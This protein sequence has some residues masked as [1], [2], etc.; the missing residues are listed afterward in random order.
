MVVIIPIETLDWLLEDVNPPVR[1]LTKEYLLDE[2]PSERELQEVNNYIPINTILSLMKKDGSWN[3]PKD[4]YKK[5]TGT[6]WQFIFLSEMQA[7]PADERIKKAAEHIFDYQLPDGGFSHR[8]SFKKP[9]ICLSANI[10]RSFVHF[11]YINHR[12]V[13]TGIDMITNHVIE[14]QGVFCLDPIYTLLPDCQMALMKVL[15]LYAALEEKNE[16]AQK[17]IRIIEDKIVE[18]NIFQYVPA[19]AKEYKKAING[20]KTSEIR[21]IKASMMKDLNKMEKKETKMSWTKFGFPHSYTS[22]A[23]EILYWLA[24]AD[25]T[26]RHEYEKAIDLVIAKMDKSGKWINENTFRNPMLVEIEAKKSFSKW[27]TFRA[28]YVLKKFRDLRFFE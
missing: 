6:Y 18:N 20:K 7:N 26:D 11:G 5:Y 17:V 10:L 14:K 16:K 19:G 4:P 2:N 3:D 12:N 28:Y 21:Q 1:N 9:I 8:L 25:R 23:L 27:L 22:D 13:Q 15:A 24:R